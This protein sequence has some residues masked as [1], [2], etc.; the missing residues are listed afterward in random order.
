MRIRIRNPLSRRSVSLGNG[1]SVSLGRGKRRRDGEPGPSVVKHP[2]RF[3][4]WLLVLTVGTV[5]L[6][7]K[8]VR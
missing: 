1:V 7:Y 4:A 8:L 5:W 3:F 2:G 6:V